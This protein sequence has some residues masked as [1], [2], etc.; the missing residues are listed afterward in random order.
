M[1]ILIATEK[2]FAKAAVDGI[3]KIIE[4]GGFTLELLENYTSSQQLYD[5]VKEANALIIRSDKVTKEVVEA[6]PNLKIVVRAG[7]GYDNVDLEACSA[8]GIVVMNTPG[9]NAN[10]V[11][12]LAIGMMIYMARNCFTPSSG[13]E[14]SGKRLGIH[15]YGSIGRLVALKGQGL[16]M[17]TYGHYRSADKSRITV[18]NVTSVDSMEELYQ[19]S[20]YISLHVPA[21]PANN[22]LVGASLLEKLPK[23]AT[24]INTA[25]KEIINQEELMQ[26]LEERADLKY[27]TDVPTENHAALVEKFGNRVYAT[28]KKMGAQTSEANINAGLAAANQIVA[29]FKEG[30]KTYQVN[31]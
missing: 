19:N 14:L 1:K 16:G 6:A 3:A 13:K 15:A 30:D 23:G 22:G 12:E 28:P 24:I 9:Q 18:D 10:A 31:K 17:S 11:A 7:A 29:F 4:K 26:V 25:R 2:P 8:K 20:D 27:A 5:A 21:I